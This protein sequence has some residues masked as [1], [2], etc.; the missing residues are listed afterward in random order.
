MSLI[1]KEEI[2][3]KF[4]WQTPSRGY[5]RGNEDVR[6]TVGKDKKMKITL[7][8]DTWELISQTDYIEFAVCKNRILFREAKD[9]GYKMVKSGETPSRYV[10]TSLKGCDGFIGDY[11]LKYD[12]FLE[13]YYVEKR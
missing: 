6:I 2:I 1:S 8:N 7:R 3:S 12:D 5:S 13:L 10:F 11:E 4:D 9:K